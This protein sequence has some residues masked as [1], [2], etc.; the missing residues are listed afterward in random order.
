MLSAKLI[1]F[2]E[3]HWREIV[4]RFEHKLLRDPGLRHFAELPESDLRG[5][6]E[7]IL[8][9]LGRWVAHP[10][11]AELGRYYEELGRLRAAESIPL[12]EVVHA[13]HLLR[14]EIISFVHD[15]GFAQTSV[16]LYAEEELEHRVSVFFDHLVCHLVRGYERALRHSMAQTA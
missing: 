4:T 14:E 3:T 5:R 12:H 16:E 11:S 8:R 1:Q 9:N 7:N 2:I 15:Q 13:L 10:E 6:A